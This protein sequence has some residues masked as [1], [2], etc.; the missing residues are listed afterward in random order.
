[1]TEQLQKYEVL[2]YNYEQIRDICGTQDLETINSLESF[3]STRITK[4]NRDA[5]EY[6]FTNIQV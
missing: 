4:Y 3:M 6:L 1:M 2:E 5:L